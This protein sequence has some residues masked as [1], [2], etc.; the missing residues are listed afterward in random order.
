MV[1]ITKY[2]QKDK[3]I[4]YLSHEHHAYIVAVIVH[5]NET[6]GTRFP[7]SGSRDDLLDLLELHAVR[8]EL[9]KAIQHVFKSRFKPIVDEPISF[10][11]L[12]YKQEVPEKEAVDYEFDEDNE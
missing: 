5:L 10:L 4:E 6:Y 2:S 9:F 7:K 8:S 11:S 1:K 3:L 12:P